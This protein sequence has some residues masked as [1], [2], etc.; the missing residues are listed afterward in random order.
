MT[1]CPHC[2]VPVI[3]NLAIHVA[4]T[5]TCAAAQLNQSIAIRR[6]PVHTVQDPEQGDT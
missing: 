4:F 6:T 1:T 5:M 3:G 2:E